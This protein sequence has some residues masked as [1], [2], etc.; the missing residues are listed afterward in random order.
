[1][2]ILLAFLSLLLISTGV[3]REFSHPITIELHHPHYG[4][5]TLS[6]TEGGIIYTKDLRIQAQ[7][8]TYTQKIEDGKPVRYVVAEKDLMLTKGDALYIG[9][10]L[11]YDFITET[12]KIYRGKTGI[13]YWFLHGEVLTIHPNR[14]VSVD[15]AFLTTEPS[16]HPLWTLQARE[17]WLTEG[18]FL[19]A[20]GA[21]TARIA[22]MPILWLP[23][24]PIKLNL[25]SS[26]DSVMSYSVTQD[27]GMWPLLGM[28]YQ[29][30]SW[31]DLKLSCS[32]NIRLSKGLGGSFESEYKPVGS[33]TEWLTRSYVDHDTFYRDV[34]PNRAQWHYRFQGLYKAKNATESTSL[35]MQYDYLSD[36]NLQKDFHTPGF[37][38]ETEKETKATFFH[39]EDHSIFFLQSQL[40]LNSF[41]TLSQ[42]LPNAKWL[43]KPR[44]LGRSGIIAEHLFS[45]GYFD[46]RFA[47]TLSSLQDFRAARFGMHS[48]LYRPFFLRGMAIT[49]LVGFYGI[50]LYKQPTKSASWASC[51]A[52]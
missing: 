36:K 49:P 51:C 38:C 19:E 16:C 10:K 37:V 22:E 28:R 34:D 7:K 33:S 40:R 27:T 9:D 20:K 43:I 31:K 39:R 45:T 15:K 25:K 26:S 1:M 8:I 46:Y 23:A 4:D 42:Q 13:H 11:E 35:S 32:V 29:F 41:Q 2:R 18:Q 12:G 6:T 48:A 17:M 50:F 30:Y 52:L 14:S 3:S 21:T 24:I 47:S 5:G 44:T